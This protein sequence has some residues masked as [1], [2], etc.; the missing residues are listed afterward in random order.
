MRLKHFPSAYTFTYLLC[1][2]LLLLAG[3]A[4]TEASTAITAV[5]V[6]SLAGNQP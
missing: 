4:P 3:C 6:S 2:A 1:L 5:P